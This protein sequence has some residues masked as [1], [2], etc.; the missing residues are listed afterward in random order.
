MYLVTI[1][2]VIT[3]EKFKAKSSQL[4]TYSE[5]TITFKTCE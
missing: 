2:A 5:V 1:Q 3:T 4:L